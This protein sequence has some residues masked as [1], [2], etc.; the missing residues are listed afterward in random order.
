MRRST[1]LLAGERN[2]V[3]C[4]GGELL[5]LGQVQGVLGVGRCSD[6]TGASP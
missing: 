3:G 5:L 6:V 1:H 2:E 4:R